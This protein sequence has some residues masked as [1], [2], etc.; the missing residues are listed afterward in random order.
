[1]K[2]I[3]AEEKSVILVSLESAAAAQ[4]SA[5]PVHWPAPLMCGHLKR[6][7]MGWTTTVTEKLT[8]TCVYKP[9]PTVV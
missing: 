6:S 7:A 8:K 2:V 3:R 9:P 1:M 4:Q 5:K